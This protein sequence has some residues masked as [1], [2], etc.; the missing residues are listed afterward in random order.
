MD[1]CKLSV[2]VKSTPSGKAIKEYCRLIIP[3]FTTLPRTIP[4]ITA[5]TF[6]TILFNFI[7]SIYPIPTFLQRGGFVK[8]NIF[9]YKQILAKFIIMNIKKIIIP[10]LINFLFTI[11]YSK[12]IIS[13]DTALAIAKETNKPVL[14]DIF[15]DW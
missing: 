10:L 12:D 7:S 4:V 15:A 3:I 9:I 5:K 13:F 1:D 2:L 6:L 11:G 14:I 8:R